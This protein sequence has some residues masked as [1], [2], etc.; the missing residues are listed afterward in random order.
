MVI[1]KAISEDLPNVVNFWNSLAGK[2]DS[3]WRFAP[4]VTVADIQ[5]HIENNYVVYLAID[6]VLVGFG[7]WHQGYMLGIAANNRDIYWKIGNVWAKENITAIGTVRFPNILC[8]EI[9][10]L[11]ELGVQLNKTP[12]SYKPLKPGEDIANRK[13]W[14]YMVSVDLK[15]VSEALDRFYGE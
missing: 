10:W 14:T 4:I 3:I 12:E 13:V 9:T 6:D 15:E 5:K 7:M 11:E 1:R 2:L 8:K